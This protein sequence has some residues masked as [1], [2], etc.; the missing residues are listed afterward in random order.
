M[1]RYYADPA[2]KP[3]LDPSLYSL[4]SDEAAFFKQLTGISDEQALKEHILAVQSKAYEVSPFPWQP[5]AS[6]ELV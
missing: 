2:T 6:D 5:V 3:K 1:S 4:D